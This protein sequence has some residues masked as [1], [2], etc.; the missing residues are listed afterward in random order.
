MQLVNSSYLLIKY[1]LLWIKYYKQCHLTN[2]IVLFFQIVRHLN[3]LRLAKD[4]KEEKQKIFFPKYQWLCCSNEP[5]IFWI[6]E[7]CK[8]CQRCDNRWCQKCLKYRRSVE[9]LQETTLIVNFAFSS[10]FNKS[11]SKNQYRGLRRS[12][13]IKNYKWFLIYKLLI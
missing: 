5:S 11:L 7:C 12:A 13:L 10:V 6:I 2:S 8:S 4:R 3:F 1:S 9:F